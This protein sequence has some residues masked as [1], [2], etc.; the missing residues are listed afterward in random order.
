MYTPS[1]W[2]VSSNGKQH[3]VPG[4]HFTTENSGKDVFTYLGQ[5]LHSDTHLQ[6]L[7]K[8]TTSCGGVFF[9]DDA[10]LSPGVLRD[11]CLGCSLVIMPQVAAKACGSNYDY[12]NYLLT[13]ANAI[14]NATNTTAT[15]AR[16]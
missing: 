4:R 11:L 12:S 15:I 16:R 8:I 1:R 14:T 7:M 6:G 3:L 5:V 13:T 10:K 9:D 2:S